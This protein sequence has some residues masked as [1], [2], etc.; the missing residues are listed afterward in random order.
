[1]ISGSATRYIC[2]RILLLLQKKFIYGVKDESDPLVQPSNHVV[3][4]LVN[5]T[6]NVVRRCLS[7]FQATISIAFSILV[8]GVVSLSESTN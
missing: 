6:S 5:S 4:S 7:Q 1:M 2:A 8:F 3:F